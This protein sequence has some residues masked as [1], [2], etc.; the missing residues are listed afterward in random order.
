VAITLRPFETT[1]NEEWPAVKEKELMGDWEKRHSQ[2]VLSHAVDDALELLI[3]I[4]I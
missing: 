4:E 1:D 2:Q 3:G